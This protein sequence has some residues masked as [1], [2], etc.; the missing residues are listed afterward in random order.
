LTADTDMLRDLLTP[1]DLHSPMPYY[2]QVIEA[3]KRPIE[4]GHWKPGDQLPSEPELTVAFGVSRAVIRQALDEMERDGLIVRRK[5]KGTFVAEPKIVEGLVQRLTGFY[6]DMAARGYV[7]RT[8]VL[9]QEV[10]P[11]TQK[12]A[13]FLGLPPETPVIVIERLRFVQAEPIVLVTT[14]LPHSLCPSIVYED[15]SQQSLYACLRE[16]CGL[17]LA[18]GRR[19]I[20]AVAARDEE[21]RLLQVERG[22]PLILL[23]SVSYLENGTP[24]EYYHALHRGDRS[25]FQVELI[26]VREQGAVREL[27]GEQPITLPPGNTL[28]QPEPAMADGR[29]L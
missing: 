22:A 1:I 21:A 14:Y 17:E 19:F 4:T 11:A 3:L 26:R 27:I 28:R 24:V 5:G 20:E 8:Q 15:L 12:V 23:D 10:I 2:G 16:K 6:E 9:R 7:T 29:S 13:E 25:R 18:R